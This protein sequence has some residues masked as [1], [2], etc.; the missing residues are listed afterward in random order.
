MNR[1]VVIV[2]ATKS[3]PVVMNAVGHALFVLRSKLENDESREF[4]DREGLSIA[5]LTDSPLICLS[6]PNSQL[7]LEIHS[8]FVANGIAS[9]AF[10]DNMR[11]GSPESQSDE[12]KSKRL[13]S[14]DCIAVASAGPN[15]LVKQLTKTLKL[16]KEGELGTRTFE[17]EPLVLPSI[18]W[19]YP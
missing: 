19:N 2:N 5:K 14:L 6:A 18:P 7:L 4:Y 11:F 1:V 16:L 10:V 15:D 12:L 8:I 3:L 13:N 9:N 17:C